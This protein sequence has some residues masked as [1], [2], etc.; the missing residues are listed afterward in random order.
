MGYDRRPWGTRVSWPRRNVR[1]SALDWQAPRPPGKSRA[2]ACPCA[3]SRCDRIVV[4]ATGPLVS[5]RLAAAIARF[6][7]T[8][9]LHF[10]DAI[11]PVVEADSIDRTIAFAASRYGKGDGA[12]YLNCPMSQEEYERFVAAVLAGE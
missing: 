9:Y 2:A 8:A 5:D 12:D 11:A 3:S 4:I 7:G 10:F 1:S 6:T